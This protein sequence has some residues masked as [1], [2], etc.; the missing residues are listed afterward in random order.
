[1][2]RSDTSQAGG[3]RAGPSSDFL[4]LAVLAA[5]A[6]AAHAWL[7]DSPYWIELGHRPWIAA[8]RAAAL[9]ID[10]SQGVKLAVI[11]GS[12]LWVLRTDAPR[13]SHGFK[14]PSLPKAAPNPIGFGLEAAR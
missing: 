9:A 7:A 10:W 13:P 8:L 1:M 2:R 4:A 11:L 12:S 6:Y 14:A 3:A 5:G